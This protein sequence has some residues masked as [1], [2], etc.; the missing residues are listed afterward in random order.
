M[1]GLVEQYT[2]KLECDIV[3]AA[4]DENKEQ[5]KAYGFVYHAMVI[6]A[7]AG[8]VQKKIDRHL[9]QEPTIRQALKEVM[10]GA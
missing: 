6:F 5:I 2:I 7:D 1:N 9:M 4:T 10:G 8:N 3:D